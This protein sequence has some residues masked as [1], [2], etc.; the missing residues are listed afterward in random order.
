MCDS[1][2]KWL[3]GD[4]DRTLAERTDDLADEEIAGAVDEA[5]GTVYSDADP[6][7]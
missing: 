1:E 5:S 3:E 2:R 6:G 4:D 7:L